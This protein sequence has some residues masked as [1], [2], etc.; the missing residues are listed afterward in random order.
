LDLGSWEVAVMG[1][2]PVRWSTIQRFIDTFEPCGLRRE[3]LAPAYGLAEGTLYVSGSPHTEPQALPVQTSALEDHRVAVGRPNSEDTRW[4]VSCGPGVSDQRIAVVNPRSFVECAACEIGEIWV[5]GPSIGRG[6]WQRPEES[7]ATFE[8]FI[9]T[10]GEGPF[11]RT[12]DLGFVHDE[13]LFVTGR[14][15]DLI[16]VHGRNVYPQDVESVVEQSHDSLRSHAAAAF[17]IELDDVERLVIVSEVEARR[18]GPLPE[19]VSAIRKA[20][21]AEFEMQAYGVVLIRRGTLP[22]TTSGKIERSRC[23]AQFLASELE[24]VDRSLLPL[25]SGAQL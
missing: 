12:G 2:E 4:V 3:T 18:P 23:K 19:V 10:S 24:I 11:L 22:I 20:V 5:S 13:R 25:G 17:S 16:I 8:A 1:A 6:Y 7:T 9:A 15:K 21:V 14:L